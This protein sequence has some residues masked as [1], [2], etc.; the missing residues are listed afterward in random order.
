[1][2]DAIVEVPDV[3]LISIFQVRVLT[4]CLPDLMHHIVHSPALD[5][6][7]GRADISSMQVYIDYLHNGKTAN[8]LN[9]LDYL[10]ASYLAILLN[11]YFIIFLDSKCACRYLVL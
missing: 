2:L 4:D 6:C 5:A 10:Q 3:E 7:V 11:L 1:M 8:P 9:H